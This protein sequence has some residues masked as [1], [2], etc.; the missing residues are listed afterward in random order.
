MFPAV[1]ST[2]ERVAFGM[3]DRLDGE[4]DIEVG[5]VKVMRTR[6]LDPCDPA[7][8][9]SLNHGNSSNATKSSSSRI[10]SQNPWGERS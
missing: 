1:H 4:I 5:P 6:Q 9:A 8:E 2:H 10:N 3:L 7:I